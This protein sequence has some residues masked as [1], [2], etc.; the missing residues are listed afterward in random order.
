MKTAG[1]FF[2]VVGPSGSGKDSLMNG[3]RL[4]LPSTSYV[5]ARRII[6]RP[7]GSPG[8]DHEG[9]SEQEF[10]ERESAGAF[11]I[12]WQ[13]HGLKYG[14]PRDLLNA[15][16]AGCH[17][18]ANG[19]RAAVAALAKMLPQLV[20]VHVTA[21]GE[22][23]AQRIAARG[24]ESGDEVLKRVARRA[25]PLAPGVK[26]VTVC[27]DA[28]LEAG[29]H[30]FVEA[31]RLVSNRFVARRMPIAA[32]GDLVAYLTADEANAQSRVAV[33]AG[34]CEQAMPIHVI[35]DP[36]L[37]AAGEIGL[38]DE[39]LARV[40]VSAGAP[41]R[42]HGVPSPSSR[43][44]LAAKL[45]GAVLSESAYE[46]ILTDAIEGRY[47]RTELTAFLVAATQSLTDAEV[48]ALARA[49]T[50]FTPR[51]EWDESIV[52]DKHSMGGVPGSRITLI[53]APIVAAY[54]LAMPKTSS[55][56][57]TSAAGTADA[58]E[59][60][61]RV[62]LTQD[63][64][65]R[66]VK[67]ARACVAWNGRL[68]HSVID[69]MMNAI[70]RP[71]GLESSRWAVASILSKKFTAGATHVIVDLPCGA[72]T[73]LA[74]R[75]HAQCLASLFETVGDG[76]G[77]HVKALVTEGNAPIGSG[78]GPALEVRDVQL[79]LHNAPDAPADLREKALCFAGRIIAFDPGVGDAA[80]G[81]RIA[82]ALLDSGAALAA[83]G[84]IVAAQGERVPP[85]MPGSFTHDVAATRGGTVA[86]IDGAG[87]SE[88]ARAA[89]APRALAAGIDLLCT[90]G[91]DVRPGR[92]L[93]RIHAESAKDLT[94]AIEAASR[95]DADGGVVRMAHA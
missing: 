34:S 90:I 82:E 9:V 20:V 56:A 84:H 47:T 75:D 42:V 60:V 13:A 43:R 25:P 46:A 6:T 33:R 36:R 66:C 61:A 45:R 53:V 69:D 63:D 80:N 93:Y 3:A 24:R 59:T 15:L 77:L 74:T 27:N 40:G 50:R 71:L 55:R 88:V 7:T 58:M 30:R 87:V 48:V 39:A 67:Q 18:V 31:L 32:Q 28:S 78:V 14:L 54:G 22:V 5:F 51:I 10:A 57:I 70:T 81:R 65:W 95:L 76:L 83:F 38:S 86:S 73:K 1:T 68:N 92:P 8:E 37:L 23:L 19:S 49:R 12:T 72:Q 4:S 94:A 41:V 44:H 35:D 91:D 21:P 26:C 89:G 79:V 16:E 62:D 2:L 64:V 17:V 29:V 85:I 52:V 11:L